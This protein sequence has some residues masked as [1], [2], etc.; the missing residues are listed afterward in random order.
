MKKL[1]GKKIKM[2]QAF[3]DGQRVGGTVIE[4]GPVTITQIKSMDRDGYW[5]VQMGFG[6]KKLKNIAK[7]QREIL[8]KAMKGPDKKGPSFL[9]EE[10][11]NEEPTDIK[12]G[13][14]IKLTDIFSVGDI[15]KVTGTSRGKG[16]AGVMKRWDFAG[17]PRT[18]GQSDRGRAPGSIGQGTDPGR[19][20]KGKKMAGR[21]GTERV[22]V[23]NLK[24]ISVDEENNKMM[25]SGPIPGANNSFV[26]IELVK[27]NENGDN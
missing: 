21:M 17:G 2:E 11:L 6:D 26:E 24:V 19:V 8:K 25:V 20:H 14:T 7:P 13:D 4:A 15:V 9:S 23:E 27:K 10:K 18:H 3:V 1:L 16:F 12:I 22:L 5:A